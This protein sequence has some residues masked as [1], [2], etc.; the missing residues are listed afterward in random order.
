MGL[1]EWEDKLRHL[2]ENL[3]QPPEE[4]LRKWARGHHEGGMSLAFLKVADK[5]LDT[6]RACSLWWLQFGLAC[7]AIESMAVGAS[8][9]DLDRFGIFHRATPRQA[10]AMLVAGTVTTKMAPVIRRLYDQMPEPR[11]VIAVGNCAISGGRFYQH[12]YSVVRGVDRVLPVDIFIPGC[13]PRPESFIDGLRKLHDLI[14]QESLAD[15][16][17]VEGRRPETYLHLR[18]LP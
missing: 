6:A 9:Y 11:Y 3:P 18:E 15:S 10:D 17:A 13:P 14:R 8:R 2:P 1:R 16:P 4:P 5:A 7:C 12:A